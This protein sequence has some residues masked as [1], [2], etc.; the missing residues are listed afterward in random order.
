[1]ENAI[2]N[3]MNVLNSHPHLLN[4]VKNQKNESFMFSND[5][6]I[7]ELNNLLNSDGHSGASFSV[8]MR[9][10]QY[11]LNNNKSKEP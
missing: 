5:P 4:Y 9:Y 3:A 1:M 8:C 10:C 6:E 7:I 2:R 11:I